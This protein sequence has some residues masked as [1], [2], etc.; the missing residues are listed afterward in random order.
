[1]RAVMDNPSEERLAFA[2]LA[3]QAI[4][5]ERQIAPELLPRLQALMPIEGAARVALEFRLDETGR[6]WVAGSAD[7]RG[8][9]TCQGCLLQ[10]GHDL[11][12]A[13]DLLIL[14]EGPDVH[15]LADDHDVLIVSGDGVTVP[16]IVEDELILALPERLCVEEPCPHS[17]GLAFPA[18]SDVVEDDADARNPFHILAALKRADT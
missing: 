8:G 14:M 7:V 6:A 4:R 18:V 15:A 11:S 12:V 9:A 13:F 1:M 16:E 17:P 2:A 3:R 5:V 10:F